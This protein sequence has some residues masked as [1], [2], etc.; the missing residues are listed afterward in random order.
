MNY[1]YVSVKITFNDFFIK[2]PDFYE[3]LTTDQGKRLTCRVSKADLQSNSTIWKRQRTFWG[4]LFKLTTASILI[5]QSHKADSLSVPRECPKMKK[6]PS[7]PGNLSH[8]PSVS[9]PPQ[10][11]T[12]WLTPNLQT[13]EACAFLEGK[14]LTFLMRSL[15]QNYSVLVS[16]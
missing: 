9:E 4:H 13:P 11:K 14:T 1:K 7:P 2:L 16:E 10:K 15:K 8:L 6:E 12:Y 3:C 5:S